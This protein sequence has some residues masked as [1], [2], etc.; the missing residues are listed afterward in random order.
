MV[1]IR[2]K[3]SQQERLTAGDILRYY[4]EKNPDAFEFVMLADQAPHTN[5]MA[6][7]T[8]GEDGLEALYELMNITQ[9][10]Q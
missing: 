10:A 3:L 9:P 1:V 4:L 6:T 8:E 5:Y 2:P 7:I